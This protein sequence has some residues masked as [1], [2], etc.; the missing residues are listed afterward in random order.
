MRVLLAC[1]GLLICTLNTACAQEQAQEAVEATLG[2]AIGTTIPHDLALNDEDADFASLAGDKGMLLFF[3][4]SVNW[5]PYCKKQII[6]ASPQFE[7]IEAKGYNIVIVTYDAVKSQED[8]TRK[9]AID[10]H[11]IAD[12]KSEIIDAFDIRDTQ[13]GRTSFAHGVS[14]P[15]IFVLD[16]NGVVKDKMYNE[17][18]Q[19]NKKSYVKRPTIEDVIARLP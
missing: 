5:C 12:R 3:V 18:Y 15:M 14:Y 10:T 2:P 17:D 13:Y 9:Y 19:T 7:S 4:R 6:D 16:E 8:F 11:F 1:L